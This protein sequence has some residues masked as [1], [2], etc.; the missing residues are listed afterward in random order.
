MYRLGLCL[1]VLVLWVAPAAACMFDTDCKPGSKCVKASG[2]LYGYC[3]GVY[4]LETTMIANPQETRSISLESRETH[5]SLTRIAAPATSA[6]KARGAFMERACR[7]TKMKG[8]TMSDWKGILLLGC[9]LF[10]AC[11]VGMAMSGRPDPNTGAL[12][13]GQARDEVLLHLGQ[14]TKTFAIATG[15]TDGFHLQRGNQASTGRA[16]GHAVMDVLTLGR[17]RL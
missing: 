3:V 16:M 9:L 5:V 10:Q 13:V 1:C 2:S 12:H 14:P 17:G 8:R 15:R 7:R 4:S 11:S 6:S